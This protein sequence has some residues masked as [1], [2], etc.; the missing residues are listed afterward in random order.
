LARVFGGFAS[1]SENRQL[2]LPSLRALLESVAEAIAVCDEQGNYLL[3]NDKARRLLGLGSAAPFPIFRFD[4]SAHLPADEFPATRALRGE[5]CRGVE[6]MVRDPRAPC[7][8]LVQASARAISDAEGRVIGAVCTFVDVKELQSTQDYLV[9]M[10]TTDELTGLP[11]YRAL[12][13]RLSD[14][15][16]EGDRGRAFAIVFA[17]VDHFK[18]INDQYGHG[19]GNEVLARVARVLRKQ[20]RNTDLV[21]RFGGEEFCILFVDVDEVRAIALAERLRETVEALEF[22]ER[23][24]VSFGVCEYSPRFADAEALMRA[25]DQALYRAKA[26]GRNCVV[27]FHDT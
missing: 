26:R 18:R 27:G 6:M 8:A 25:A 7:G 23:L 22:A 5:E 13:S 24:T 16:A 9:M 2:L 12:R 11:N 10:A 19:T 4:G 3:F 1:E 14:L 21:A 20:V 15:W 17:D